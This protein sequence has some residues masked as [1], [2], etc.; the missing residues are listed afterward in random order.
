MAWNGR[1]GDEEGRGLELSLGLPGY[2]SKS[3]THAAA[4]EEKGSAGSAAAATARA[5]GSNGFK[6]SPA[7]AAPVVGWPPVRA[8]RRNLA[9]WSSKPPSHEPSSQ[10]GSDPTGAGKAV[11]AGKKG[12][13]VKINM[14]GVPIGRKVDLR[15]HAGYDTLSAAVDHLFRGLLAAQ[16][17]GGEQEVITGVLNGSGEYTLVY[18]D[19]EGD[20]MLVGDVPWEMFTS[21]ARRLRV[22]RSSDLSPSSL[23]AA[24]RKRAAAEC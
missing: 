1:F 5:K 7:A 4:L 14:D 8:F 22:L 10:R 12:L 24:S 16:T 17:S 9:S 2:F 13:F 18:E 3:P 11:E 20:Q 15:A 21:T 23:R 6:A 19:E